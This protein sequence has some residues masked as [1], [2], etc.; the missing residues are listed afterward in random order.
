MFDAD[1]HEVGG[2][3]GVDRGNDDGVELSVLWDG[4][5][6]GQLCGPCH[7]LP[8]PLL[9]EL[10]I[11]HLSLFGE[12]DGK[13]LFGSVALLIDVVERPVQKGLKCVHD[14]NKIGSGH[15]QQNSVTPAV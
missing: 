9:D 5:G 15:T 6:V 1:V 8:Q 10:V 11:V 2:P 3:D 7:P 13:R 4:L 12:R 14:V